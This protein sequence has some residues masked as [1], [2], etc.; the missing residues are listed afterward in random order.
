MS[1]NA[2]REALQAGDATTAGARLDAVALHQRDRHWMELRGIAHA[3]AGEPR[4]AIDCFEALL[5]LDPQR[6]DWR[7]NLGCAQLDAGEVEAARATLAQACASAP[8][9]GQ[10]WHN[11]GLAQMRLGQ[12]AQAAASLQQAAQRLPRVAEIRI[13]AAQ[14]LARSGAPAPAREALASLGEQPEL[15]AEDWQQLGLALT[16]LRETD[17]ALHAYAQVLAQRP[18]DPAAL[19]AAATLKEQANQPEDAH[20]LLAQLEPA[21]AARPAAALVRARLLA[22]AGETQ[23]AL[24]ALPPGEIHDAELAVEC[25][26]ERARLLDRHGDYAGAHAQASA[27]KAGARLLRPGPED[28][29]DHLLA[30]GLKATPEWARPAHGDPDADAADTPIFLIGLPR[31][32]TTLLDLMLD[33]HPRL[34]V[35]SEQPLLDE[36]LAELPQRG[37]DSPY[38]AALDDLDAA[39]LR[40]LQLL[41]FD[42]ANR[43]LNGRRPGTRLVDKNP[44]NLL[45]LPLIARLFP[46]APILY[47]T[48]E[49]RDTALSCLLNDLGGRGRQ[50]FWS[51]EES[52]ALLDRLEGFAAEQADLLGLRM[53][54]VRYESLVREPEATLGAVCAYLGLAPDAAMRDTAATAR[55]RGA[56]HT[57]SYVAVTRAPTDARIGHWRHYADFFPADLR[58]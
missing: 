22:R 34:Q 52:L 47:A 53:H 35:L 1:L 14:C 26:F 19:I 25:A 23:A 17:A 24:E 36:L 56:L 46:G 48:R 39:A 42:A 27:A 16:A 40:R 43:R 12:W 2:A 31:S 49:H 37:G 28:V 4:A 32:G 44:L 13:L 8:E 29:F 55:R 11:L 15:S 30:Q 51:L 33:G 7:I 6:A 45:R 20:T 41:Y 38:P 50:G 5:R 9:Q 18:G 3:L 58:D 57:P 21:A 54:R 10:G